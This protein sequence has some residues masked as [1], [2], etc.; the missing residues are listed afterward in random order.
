MAHLDLA[1][2]R[3]LIAV[4]DA[5]SLTA[6]APQLFLSQSAVSEQIK[7][8][9]DCVGKPLLVRSKMGAAYPLDVPLE[10]SVGY[11]P[12]WDAAAH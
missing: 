11:G 9:E 3:T 2:L 10:V 5:G 1:Q 8:L 7:K 4:V 12:S 6:A